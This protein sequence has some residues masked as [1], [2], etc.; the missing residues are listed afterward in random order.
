MDRAG[1]IVLNRVAETQ[2]GEHFMFLIICGLLL[3]L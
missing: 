1:N 3:K 2:G